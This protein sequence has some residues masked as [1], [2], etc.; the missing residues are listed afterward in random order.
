MHAS[1]QIFSTRDDQNVS[2]MLQKC[3]LADMGCTA[4]PMSYED[5]QQHLEVMHMHHHEMLL[6]Q[7][8]AEQTTLLLSIVQP[9][10]ALAPSDSEAN[11]PLERIR[12]DSGFGE[13]KSYQYVGDESQDGIHSQQCMQQMLQQELD[14][15][16]REV[17]EQFKSCEEQITSLRTQ[18][19]DLEIGIIARV[20]DSLDFRLASVA[21]ASCDPGCLIWKISRYSEHKATAT[22]MVSPSFYSGRY[23]YKMCLRLYIMGDGIGKGTHLSLFFVVML[24]E[25]D[26]LLQ[27]PF[28]HKV[29]FKLINQEGGTD[30][31]DTFEPHII[32]PIQN[33]MNSA[34]GCPRLIS[35]SELEQGG[36][37]VDNTLFIKC[38]IDA[39]TIQH[40]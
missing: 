21:S 10:T 13:D 33:N 19:T 32:K 20:V 26:N 14:Q 1:L 2:E 8:A 9:F 38:I 40:P 12:C 22:S 39:S 25:F 17:T 36:F 18:I 30:I 24:G 34:S 27:W 16:N 31:V 6:L 5:L 35:H 28:T 11:A 15:L 37:I 7:P 3:P 29:T 4:T 23:G